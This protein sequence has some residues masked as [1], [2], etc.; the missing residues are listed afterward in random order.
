MKTEIYNASKMGN[1]HIAEGIRKLI[2]EL[3]IKES[4]E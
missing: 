2:N 3:K 4:Q 1:N